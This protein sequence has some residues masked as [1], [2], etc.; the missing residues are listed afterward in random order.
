MYQDEPLGVAGVGQ[1]WNQQPIL[2]LPLPTTFDGRKPFR[3]LGCDGS[4]A[5]DAALQLRED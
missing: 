5:H 3:D 4:S 1:E 2:F